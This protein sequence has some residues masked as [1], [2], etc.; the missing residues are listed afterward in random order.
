MYLN[1]CRV[2]ELVRARAA[3]QVQCSDTQ[4]LREVTYTDACSVLLV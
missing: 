1:L 4:C 2:T 3:L